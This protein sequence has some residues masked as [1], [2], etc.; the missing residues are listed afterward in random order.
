MRAL[1]TILIILLA[2]MGLFVILGLM[3]PRAFRVERSTV[4]AAPAEVVFAR[5]GKLGEMKNWGPWQAMDKDQVQHIEGTDGTVGAVW[6]WEGD[7]VGKGMQEII[8]IEPNKSVRTRLTFLEPMKAVNEGTYDLEP[9]GDSTRIT[10]GLQGENG[11]L[12]RVMGLF[13]DMDAMI[14]PDFERGLGNLK[15][16]AEADAL[17]IARQQAKMVDG[18]EVNIVER[19]ALWYLGE[20]KRVKWMDMEAFYS[21]TFGKAMGITHA[22]AVQPAAAPSGLFYAWDKVAQE[23]DMMAGIP[24]P[25]GAKDKLKGMA[26]VEV[27]AGKAYVIDHYGPYAQTARAHEAIDKKIKADGAIKGEVV[28]E[29]YITDPATEPDTA[30]WLT[31]VVYMLK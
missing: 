8:A 6:K 26:L 28:I 3:G 22:A 10:W 13:M 19:P 15:Q 1:K 29:E 23:A 21:R 9:L 2:L 25:A 5:V 20:R 27:P 14:G 7:T 4:I 31:R 11:L 30:K 17:A 16:L 12:G 24:V 18:F